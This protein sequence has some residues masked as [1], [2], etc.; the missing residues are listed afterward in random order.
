MIKDRETDDLKAD[1]TVWLQIFL[2]LSPRNKSAVT[3]MSNLAPSD[4]LHNTDA[5]SQIKWA[6]RATSLSTNSDPFFFYSI[7]SAASGMDRS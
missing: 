7:P 6:S 1:A 2:S 5:S 3:T 4:S